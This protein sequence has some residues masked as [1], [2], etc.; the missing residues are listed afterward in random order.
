[1]ESINSKAEKYREFM[2][3]VERTVYMD[4][5][6]PQANESVLKTGLDQFGDIKNISFIPNYMDPRN[7]MR[8]ALVEMKDHNQAKNVIKTLTNS[9]FMIAG[10]PRP[11]RVLPVELKMFDDR[12]RKPGRKITFNWLEADDPDFKVTKD[13]K[14]A[15]VSNVVKSEF[16]CRN[17]LVI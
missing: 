17:V 13:M 10:M 2:E 11:V 14:R 6:P 15:F 4:T 5:L 16:L 3:K 1:M 8:C 7:N 12:P 9:P